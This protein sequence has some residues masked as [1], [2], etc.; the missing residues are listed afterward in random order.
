MIRSASSALWSVLPGTLIRA[1][2]EQSIAKDH[3]TAIHLFKAKTERSMAY[4]TALRVEP[5]TL[6]K[7][8]SGVVHVTRH[9]AELDA[10]HLFGS[11]SLNISKAY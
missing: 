10:A 4:P 8:E 6:E 11:I 7:Y 9:E 1:A 3:R 2:T 5:P